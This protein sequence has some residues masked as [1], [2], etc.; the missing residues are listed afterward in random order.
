MA[1][2]NNTKPDSNKPQTKKP[3]VQTTGHAWDGDIQEF[4][5]PLP[6][7][8][9]WGFYASIVFAIVYW[10]LFPAWPIGNDY[11]KGV[12]NDIEYTTADG[13][14]VKTHWNT[15]ALFE[16][17]MREAEIKQQKYLDQ[18]AS[19]SIEDIANDEVKSNFAYSMAKVLYAD[20]CAAC[21]QP[22]GAGVVG[23][24]PNLADDAWL[25]GGS[26][27]QIKTS[28]AAGRNGIMPAFSAKLNATQIDDVAEYVL[29][30]SKHKTDVA[31]TARGK[32][33]FN[34]T[35]GGCYFCHTKAGSGMESMGAAN[36]TDSVW[37]LADVPA[38]DNLQAKKEA[39]KAII[40]KGVNRKMPP[41]DERLTETQIKI[42][43]FYV[44]QLGGGK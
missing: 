12:M 29:S 26:F 38:A 36:L 4:N 33:I 22:G 44:H 43:A 34:S 19:A 28:I 37:T 42:L 3:A 5:N 15:R 35:S 1:S 2:T 40:K 30:L 18:L 25:W 23:A 21:H 24:Y 8:W 11:T 20:N 9:V 16:K 17:N 14:Q 41:W 31:K 13:K 39:V 10:I 27:E 6:N 7:W 32:E